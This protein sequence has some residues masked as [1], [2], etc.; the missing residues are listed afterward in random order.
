MPDVK[1]GGTGDGAGLARALSKLGFCSRSEGARLVREGRVRVD[2]E[3]VRDPLR[4]V[5]L[6][7]A[8]IQIDGETVGAEKKIYLALNKPRGLVTTASDE[9]GRET[10]YSCFDGADLPHLSAVGR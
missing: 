9:R 8:T 6:K 5:D 2:G 3:V 4:A 7:R 10:V 1:R